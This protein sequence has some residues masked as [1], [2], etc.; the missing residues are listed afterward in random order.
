MRI[1]VP[2]LLMLLASWQGYNA[3][4]TL[5]RRGYTAS[6]ISV[7]LDDFGFLGWCEAGLT[8]GFLWLVVEIVADAVAWFKRR[9]KL[10][11]VDEH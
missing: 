10:E 1:F 4:V 5:S 3:T 9:R 6:E 2:L 11:I 8:A 7:G